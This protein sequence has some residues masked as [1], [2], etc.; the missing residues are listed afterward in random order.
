MLYAP[1]HPDP[2]PSQ[3]CNPPCSLESISLTQ[4]E[5]RKLPRLTVFQKYDSNIGPHMSMCVALDPCAM[6]VFVGLDGVKKP[7]SVSVSDPKR[8][9]RGAGKKG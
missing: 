8:E 1:G 2:S 3:P 5:K 9:G 7:V 6:D 4:L